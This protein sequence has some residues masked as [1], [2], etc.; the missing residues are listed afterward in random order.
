MSVEQRR[1]KDDWLLTK[2]GSG[3][4]SVK[5]LQLLDATSGNEL[6]VVQVGQA[7]ELRL[8]AFIQA[9]IPKLVLG[10]M[11]RDKQGHVVWGTNTWHTSQVQENVK[12]GDTVI[13]KL[14]LICTM[15]PG[16]YSVSPALCSTDTH[17]INN[18]EWIDNLLVFDVINV[19]KDYFI[20]SNWLDAQFLIS[21]QNKGC[22]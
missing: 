15:G 6:A 21:R 19:E 14:F 1:V 11:I 17:M 12:S 8:E 9:D 7:V 18:Y 20:G 13:F 16:S 22:I 4:A 5:S 3:E 2:S 10:F